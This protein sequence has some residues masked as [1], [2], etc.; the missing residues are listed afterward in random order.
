MQEAII[1]AAKK[2]KEA[3]EEEAKD[4]DT[5]MVMCW[6]HLR[7]IWFKALV[8]QLIRYLNE[9]MEEH[10]AQIDPVDRIFPGIEDLIRVCE[11]YFPS[12]NGTPKAMD[13]DSKNRWRRSIQMYFS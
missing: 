10:L 5:Y 6:H 13:R 9:A 8:K 2:M 12:R 11:K 1:D 7:N 3:A 4:I